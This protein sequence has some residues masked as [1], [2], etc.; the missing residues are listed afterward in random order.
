M[1]SITLR[2]IQGVIKLWNQLFKVPDYV[3][4][5]GARQF[6]NKCW[7]NITGPLFQI[8]LTE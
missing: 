7:Y 6:K 8:Y 3:N 2:Y 5:L 1:F 4:F